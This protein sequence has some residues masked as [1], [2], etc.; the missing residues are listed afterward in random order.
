[1]TCKFKDFPSFEKQSVCQTHDHMISSFYIVNVGHRR[2]L[3]QLML[4]YWIQAVSVSSTATHLI[5]QF[6]FDILNTN[7]TCAA[8]FYG[9]QG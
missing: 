6:D 4:V 5:S 2:S 3:D 7:T 9:Q 8:L 1:M